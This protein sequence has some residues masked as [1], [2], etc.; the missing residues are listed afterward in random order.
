MKM[1]NIDLEDWE[2]EEIGELELQCV[3]L[4]KWVVKSTVHS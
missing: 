3:H 4:I 1:L 2:V